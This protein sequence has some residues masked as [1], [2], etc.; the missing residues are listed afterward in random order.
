MITCKSQNKLHNFQRQLVY[1]SM[2]MNIEFNNVDNFF[3]S[4]IVCFFFVHKKHVAVMIKYNY[5]IVSVEFL[6]IRRIIQCSP[7]QL[8]IRVAQLQSRSSLYRAF[9]V[10]SVC[11]LGVG[12]FINTYCELNFKSI[13]LLPI[14]VIRNNSYDTF[15]KSI[16]K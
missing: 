3:S 14:T 16:F 4:Y 15:Y 1:S 7:Q 6:C 12:R 5:L 2:Y 9:C 10:V 13:Q 8:V 11:F